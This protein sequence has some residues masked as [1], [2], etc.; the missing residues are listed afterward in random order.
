MSKKEVTVTLE[1]ITPLWTGDAWQ[2]SKEIRPSSLM[3]S[4]R[5]WFEVISY[6]SGV[7]SKEDFNKSNGRF[8][9]EVNQD[10]FK[11]NLKSNGTD[12]KSQIEILRGMDIPVPS[13]IF[14]TTGWRSLI[15]IKEI[16]PLDD[17]CFGNKINLPERICVSKKN[18]EVKESCDC[19]KRSN[20]DWS[21]FYL[22]N[23]YFYGVFEVKF[24]VEEE[25]LDG[26]FYPLL[27]FMDEYGY[28]GGKWNIGYGR[29]K[30][31]KV[32]QNNDTKDNW[33]NNKKFNFSFGNKEKEVD[34]SELLELVYS[35]DD[36]SQIQGSNNNDKNIKILCNQIQNQNLEA[37]I[38][39]LI[40]IKAKK[41]A[42]DKSNGGNPEKRHKIF[43]TVK[44]PPNSEDLPQGSKIL[45]FIKEENGNYVGGFVSIVDLLKLYERGERND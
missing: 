17:Y 1:T 9:K 16:K 22:P 33:K 45:P 41:R 6:F 18:E 37:V 4:L 12:V 23:P 8:E 13:I 7:C 32:K 34:L 5:F 36:L 31:R 3:G 19:P 27:N 43:G 10:E 25:I 20:E 29:L 30:I 40:K 14:G 21:V 42:E 11:K 44:K 38:K 2:D 26:I 39:E 15:E 24:L 28:W 35:F